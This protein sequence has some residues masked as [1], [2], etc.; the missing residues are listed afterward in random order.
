MYPSR[1][2]RSPG[3]LGNA[4]EQELTSLAY[5]GDVCRGKESDGGVEGDGSV[6]GAAGDGGCVEV[7]GG[8]GVSVGDQASGEDGRW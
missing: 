8:K 5:N 4:V 1:L 2:C 6:G 3:W 7:E